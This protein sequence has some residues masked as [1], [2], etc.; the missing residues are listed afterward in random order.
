MQSFRSEIENPL[1]PQEIITLEHQIRAYREGKIHDEK[2]RSLRLARGIYGQRQPGVQMVRIKIPFGK[3]T[4][5]Q[6]LK[7][8]YLADEYASSNL[9]FTTRQD[10]QIHFVSLDRTPEL[11]A[12]LAE[13]EITI[14]EACSNT[15]RNVT[16]SST[17][18][19]DPD[20]PFDVSPYAQAFFKYFLGN[21][22]SLELGRK[23]KFGFSSSEKDTA[24]SF[25]NDI[26]FIPKI[27]IISGKEVRGFKVVL[28]GSLGAQPFIGKEVTD[29]L[30]ED[31]IIPFSEAVLRVFDRYGER[32]NR[33]KARLKFLLNK[34]SFD[35]FLKMVDEERIAT[36]IKSFSIDRNTIVNPIIPELTQDKVE[37]PISQKQAYELW[38]STNVYHQKQE[39]YFG[40]FVKVKT[41][42]M[43]TETVRKF[44][45]AVKPFVAEELRITINQGLLLKYVHEVS[46]P[47]LF[48]ALD[49]LDL[50]APGHNSVA[51]VT[52][53]PGTDTCN[54]G[55]SNSM[56]LSRVLETVV[57]S[58][59]ETFVRNKE[60][61]IK[62]SGCMNSCGQHGI[63]HIGFHGSSMKI[64]GSILP[65]VQV[66]LGGGALGNGEGRPA[67]KI[68]KVPSK[69]APDV[70]RYVLNDYKLYMGNYKNFLQYY[71]ANGKDYF[72][73]LLKPLADQENIVADDFIDWG[74]D[75]NFIR[76]IGVGECA[77]VVI[78]LVATL[79]YETEEKL[80]WA[81]EAYHQSLWS[82]AIYNAYNTFI[83]G[84]KSILLQ[85]GINQ[86]TQIGIINAFDEQLAKDFS[87]N[88]F[89][90]L[91]LQINK[92]EPSE[93]FAKTYLAQAEKFLVQIK[94]FKILKL[95]S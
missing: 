7:V 57:Y 41:G 55:I 31:L 44:V 51:D 85:K 37:I 43:S 83:S 87:I 81:V 88:S 19:I 80:N 34:L 54:L 12:K 29:F 30:H 6:L 28:G 67:E 39:G 24:Y 66:L 48:L 94:H 95:V 75:K 68:V 49:K 82:D 76:A 5:K 64:N 50:A 40:V 11:W 17:A 86:S 18:G 14:R 10:I 93:A 23:F 21:T 78:D 91:V 59:Y 15:V 74:Q 89:A 58:E 63:A 79:L 52:T 53:C 61:K 65:A 90:S 45:A 32:T 38:H 2:F 35:E 33:N 47:A 73:Q 1:V 70:L 26:G 36:K 25:I 77:G 84:A 4:F 9:H 13:D 56:E 16:A 27:K 42:D 69:R 62:I 71:E 3:L 92:N 72:Y 46:L 22:V 20:E 60:I 8:A